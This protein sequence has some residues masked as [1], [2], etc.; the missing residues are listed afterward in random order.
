M[1]YGFR[2]L[3]FFLCY[4]TIASCNQNDKKLQ[5]EYYES[6]K[7]KK[8]GWYLKSKIPIDTTFYYF[9]NG[10][11]ERIEVRDDSGRLNGITKVFGD[12]GQVSQEISYINN[13]VKGFINSY[14]EKG[15]LMSRLFYLNNRQLGDGYWYG[16]AGNIK[17]YGFNGFGKDYRNFIKYNDDG[18]IV[19]KIA[20]LIFIDSISTYNSTN[21]TVYDVSLLLS[22]APNCRTSVLIDYLSSDSISKK[23]DS[24]MSQPYYFKK[25]KFSSHI[26]RIIFH[27]KQFDSLTGKTLLQNMTRSMR[28]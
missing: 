15:E 3:I 1:Q 28:N 8:S 18:E 11:Y 21:E 19:E 13:S 26:D 6:G 22:N 25:E 27:G 20:P 23:Q 7:L 24:V 4:I 5:K 9:E 16:P 17:Q 12:N 10:N 2:F 14:N